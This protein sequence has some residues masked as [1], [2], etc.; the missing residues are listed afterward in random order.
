MVAAAVSG[1]IKDCISSKTLEVIDECEPMVSEDD[2]LDTKCEYS[3]PAIVLD[4]GGVEESKH[5]Q[6]ETAEVK[7]WVNAVMPSAPHLTQGTTQ[8][9]SSLVAPNRVIRDQVKRASL[10]MPDRQRK[11]VLASKPLSQSSVP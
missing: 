11:V 6:D 7:S 8:S 5:E 1:G 2:I 4:D 9:N 3:M 10:Q